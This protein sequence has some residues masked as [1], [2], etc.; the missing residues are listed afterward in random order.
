[1]KSLLFGAVLLLSLAASTHGDEHSHALK[2]HIQALM[3]QVNSKNEILTQW[4]RKRKEAFVYTWKS[5]EHDCSEGGEH[6]HGAMCAD[7]ESYIRVLKN[8]LAAMN[9]TALNKNTS[10]VYDEMVEHAEEVSKKMGDTFKGLVSNK[11]LQAYVKKKTEHNGMSGEQHEHEM[12]KSMLKD[13]IEGKL[14]VMHGSSLNYTKIYNSLPET[15][16]YRT[17]GQTPVTKH[18]LNKFLDVVNDEAYNRLKSK[19]ARIL[20]DAAA[21]MKQH[22]L[23]YNRFATAF[24]EHKHNK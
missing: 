14:D 22:A 1:M 16:K 19:S 3:P 12:M 15:E 11:D 17:T 2:P 4:S 8:E 10:A 9:D 23:R 21:D 20:Q 7:H 18:H 5:S 13:H 24:K 6:I